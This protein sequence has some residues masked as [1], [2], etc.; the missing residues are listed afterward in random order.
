[1]FCVKHDRRAGPGDEPM[2]RAAG[3]DLPN[4]L[5]S[6]LGTRLNTVWMVMIVGNSKTLDRLGFGSPTRER[7]ALGH[8]ARVGWRWR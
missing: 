2:P 4:A 3:C 1:M 7:G 6:R 5:G 8:F